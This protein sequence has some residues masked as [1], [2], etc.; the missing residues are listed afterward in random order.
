[1]AYGSNTATVTALLKQAAQEHADVLRDPEFSVV[2][3][4]FGDNA[5]MSELNVWANA[6][7]ERSLRVI[8]SDLR[9]RIEQLFTENDVV[10]SFPQAP[11]ATGLVLRGY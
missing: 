8:R 1:M 6:S 11:R 3:D 10:I 5:L 7:A 2:F 4:D 9:Y